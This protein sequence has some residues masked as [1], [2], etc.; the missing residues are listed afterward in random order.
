M[1]KQLNIDIGQRIRRERNRANL[2]R[3]Q[4]AELVDV[5]PRFIAD[6]ERGHVG[7]SV[8]TLKKLCEVLHVSSDT[9]LWDKTAQTSI[10]DKL[11]LIDSEYAHHIEKMVQTQLD[12]IA[13]IENK[14]IE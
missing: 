12:F 8:P 1:K 11:K 9:L 4:L 2:T 10:D 5:T 13:F 7:I 6:V 14:D 3:E